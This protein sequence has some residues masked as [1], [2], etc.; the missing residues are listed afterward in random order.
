MGCAYVRGL[1][2]WQAREAARAAGLSSFFEADHL[3]EQRIL[4]ALLGGV[5]GLQGRT[6]EEALRRS[7][8]GETLAE[9]LFEHDEVFS[10]AHT[11]LMPANERVHYALLRELRRMAGGAGAVERSSSRVTVLAWESSSV[12]APAPDRCAAT[13][14]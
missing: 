5:E 13:G 2:D 1:L 14:P 10:E 3:L 11:L 6:L 7:S 9:D 12:I 4:R 8:R